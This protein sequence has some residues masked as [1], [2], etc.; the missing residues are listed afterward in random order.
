MAV[1][2]IQF[3]YTPDAWASLSRNPVDR[4]GP[5]SG[6]AESLGGKLLNLY[7]CF[8][9]Y[10]GIVIFEAPDDASAAALSVSATIPGHLKMAKTTR[11]FTPQESLELL[12]KAGGVSFRGPSAS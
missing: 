1:Y 7:Y 9:E 8:G 5:I 12:R 6:L 11:L 3:T 2:M 4:S 10:D